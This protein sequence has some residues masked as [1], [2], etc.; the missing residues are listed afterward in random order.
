MA[1]LKKPTLPMCVIK[2]KNTSFRK[3]HYS[4]N[5]CIDITAIKSRTGQ[6]ITAFYKTKNTI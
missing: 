1:I 5:M 3:V 4:I 6:A 2:V